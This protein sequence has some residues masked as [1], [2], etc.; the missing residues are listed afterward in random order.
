VNSQ[1]TQHY[2]L[3][4]GSPLDGWTYYRLKQVD[5]DGSM[6][7]SET[8]MVFREKDNAVYVWPQPNSGE[9][10]VS[11]SVN[12]PILVDALGRRV[13]VEVMAEGTS[14]LYVVRLVH[15]AQGAYALYDPA[16]P[17]RSARVVID[18]GGW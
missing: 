6:R 4:D 16:T 9:F 14:G 13:L 2:T 5:T 17:Q 12:P 8:V 18:G 15:P 3:D 11:G 1:Q 10:H 7:I